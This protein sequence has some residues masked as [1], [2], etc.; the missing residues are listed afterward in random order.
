MV[1]IPRSK[2]CRICVQRRVKCDQTRP[3]CNNCLRGNRP[4][5]GYDTDLRI[6]DE[7]SKLRKRFGQKDGNDPKIGLDRPSPS[8]ASSHSRST[9]SSEETLDLISYQ[10]SPYAAEQPGYR[11]A[12]MFPSRNPFLNILE[13]Q[14]NPNLDL[15]ALEPTPVD[16]S[17]NSAS[18]IEFDM[19]LRSTV[20]SPYIAQE[21]L[22]STF[23]SAFATHSAPNVLPAYLRN[24]SR[25][26]SQLPAFFGTK[27]V[28]TAV[29]AVSL[30]HLG[31]VQQTEALVQE[32]RQFYGNALRL[33]NQALSDQGKGM[34]TETLSATILLSFYEMLASESNASWVRHAGGAGA[35][36]RIRGPK[37]HLRGIDRDV[38]LAYRHTIVI[39]AFQRDEACFLAQP[40]WVDMARQVH[41]E[42]RSSGISHERAE[43]F[44]LA[45]EFYCEN[46]HIPGTFAEAKNLD[47]LRPVLTP[48]QYGILAARILDRCKQHR[49][50]LKS[51]NMKFRLALANLG[52]TT[53]SITANDPIFPT[54]Y[55]Y[56][57][58]FVGSTQ[59]GYWTILLLLN[60]VLKEME[61]DSA[62]EMTGLYLMENREIAREICRSAPYMMTSSFLGPFFVTFALRLCLMV[63]EPGAERDWVVRK[64]IHIGDTRM[65][66]ASD[67][68]DFVKDGK[69]QRLQAPTPEL[70][71]TGMA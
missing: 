24:H 59:V 30:V 25:W 18:D 27:L 52:L 7:G 57:N 41:E 23:S 54:Q 67:L 15:F 19:T 64:L 45:E 3:V 34:A 58:V 69:P 2:G 10:T 36:M 55:V 44:D 33:L 40:E 60:L 20:F 8:A 29:R 70:Y 12:D 37:R 62:Q 22:L 71:E 68:A 49:S 51:I 39:D 9:E 6:H 1:G 11:G 17:T 21:Q 42:L 66:M 47:G 56:V 48:G 43:I 61:K 28:D 32:S 38:Y 13:N 5:P 26:L 14:I 16:E 50:N 63:F 53:M 46:V 31:R 65:R 35:L 4:C